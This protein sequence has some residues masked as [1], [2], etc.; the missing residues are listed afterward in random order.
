MTP[1]Q[2]TVLLPFITLLME[3]SLNSKTLP[4]HET[5]IKKSLGA[6]PHIVTHFFFNHSEGSEVTG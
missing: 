1:R 6:S 5:I 2:L 3:F 4:S